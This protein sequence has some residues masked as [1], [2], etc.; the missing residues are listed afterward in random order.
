[1]LTDFL[2]LFGNVSLSLTLKNG[3][4]S[5]IILDWYCVFSVLEAVIPLPSGHHGFWWDISYMNHTS[6]IFRILSLTFD[7]NL[8]MMCVGVALFAY[9]TYIIWA[10]WMCNLLFLKSNLR[11][12][13]FILP[14][15]FLSSLLVSR[16]IDGGGMEPWR[17]CPFVFIIFSFSS[18][19][20]WSQLPCLQ[21]HWLFILPSQVCC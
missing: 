3:F 1:M 8:V 16:Y 6:A 21:V 10:S 7:N 19:T 5:N 11:Q 20:S 2:D 12:S 18:L 13:F 14:V 17:L 9:F 4:A 15:L